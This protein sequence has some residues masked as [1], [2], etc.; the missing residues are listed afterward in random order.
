MAVVPSLPCLSYLHHFL[1]NPLAFLY[2]IFHH[3]YS[4]YVSRSLSLLSQGSSSHETITRERPRLRW[5]DRPD[6]REPNCSVQS[7]LSH[8][9]ECFLRSLFLMGGPTR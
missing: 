1:L 8:R 6:Q 7:L 5:P 2:L 4:F 9:P 3:I